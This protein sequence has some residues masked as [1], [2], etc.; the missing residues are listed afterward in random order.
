M[1]IEDRPVEVEQPPGRARAIAFALA[2]VAG[3]AGPDRPFGEALGK[4][5][6]PQHLR[7]DESGP[8]AEDDGDALGRPMD[9]ERRVEEVSQAGSRKGREVGI[10]GQARRHRAGLNRG[11]RDE[12]LAGVDD[13]P[14]DSTGGRERIQKR[15]SQRGPVEDGRPVDREDSGFGQRRNG[16][17]P[18]DYDLRVDGRIAR[19]R[20]IGPERGHAGGSS[21]ASVSLRK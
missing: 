20:L 2:E 19:V 5:R 13:S 12:R 14:D 17:L 10:V 3:R 18:A 11:P 15:C 6:K 16:L 4:V 21:C 9:T 1:A 8:W 7:V